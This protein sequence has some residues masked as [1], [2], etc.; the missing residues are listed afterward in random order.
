AAERRGDERKRERPDHQIAAAELHGYPC[1]PG[2]RN[3][4]FSVTSHRVLAAPCGRRDATKTP[5]KTGAKP[6]KWNSCGCSPR[7]TIDMTVPNTGTRW[8]NGA[9]RLAPISATP[10]LKQR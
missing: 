6:M 8:K 10:R 3:S 9:A 4:G 1:E 7:K 5:V 2:S